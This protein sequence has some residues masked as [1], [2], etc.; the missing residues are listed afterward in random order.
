VLKAEAVVS[1]AM[2]EELPQVTHPILT[3][4]NNHRE[5]AP[6]WMARPSREQYHGYFE[7]EYGAQ[8]VFV[9]DYATETGQL[10]GGDVEW[11]DGCPVQEGGRVELILNASERQWLRACWSAATFFRSV[12]QR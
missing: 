12:R 3:I 11:N 5:P 1:G 4:Y 9:Y 8:W 6:S 7:N 10:F 2:R